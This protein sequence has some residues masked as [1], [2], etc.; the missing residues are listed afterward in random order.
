MAARDIEQPVGALHGGHPGKHLHCQSGGLTLC[1]VEHCL[2]GGAER[3]LCEVERIEFDRQIRRPQGGVRQRGGAVARQ[4]VIVCPGQ[5]QG[6]DGPV[7]HARG[8]DRA[9]GQDL[10]ILAE[11]QRGGGL[12]G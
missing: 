12:P 1:A 4:R 10:F 8:D 2:V 6:G 5:A 3:D 11:D 9:E 7:E